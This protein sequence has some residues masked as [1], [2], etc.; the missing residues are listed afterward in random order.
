[1]IPNIVEVDESDF[2]QNKP[3]NLRQFPRM[4]ILRSHKD[5]SVKSAKTIQFPNDKSLHS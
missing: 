2:Q 5:Q 4:N 1:M 3:K